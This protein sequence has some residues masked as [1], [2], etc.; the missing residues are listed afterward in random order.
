MHNPLVSCI[1]PVWNGEKYLEEAIQS[2]LDQTYPELEIV[3]VDDGSTDGTANIISSFEGRLIS[4]HQEQAGP[5]AAR[6]SGIEASQGEFVA[7]LD[8]DDIWEPTKTELQVERLLSREERSI[9]LCKVKNFWSP[10]IARTNRQFPME[11][12]EPISGWFAQSMMVRSHAFDSIGLFDISLRHREAME[13]LRRAT[14][15]GDRKSTRLNSSHSRASR[16]PSSA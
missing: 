10:E 1:I 4:I 14:D 13:W 8:A 5:A 15:S 7:F 12:S 6:N 3:V 9:C 2:V 11:E 16:M